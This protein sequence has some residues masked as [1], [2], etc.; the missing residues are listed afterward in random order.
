MADTCVTP[1]GNP[2]SS[3]D[4]EVVG[5]VINDDNSGEDLLVP[6]ISEADVPGPPINNTQ[7]WGDVQGGVQGDIT[8]T[9]YLWDAF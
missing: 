6:S 1:L 5:G 3:E 2:S 7:W 4:S 9:L 8:L